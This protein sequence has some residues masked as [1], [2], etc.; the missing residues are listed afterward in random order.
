[1][2]IYRGKGWSIIP[3]SILERDT[4]TCQ[5]CGKLGNRQTLTAHHR[6]PFRLFKDTIKANHPRNLITLCKTCH[7]NAD[8]EYWLRHPHLFDMCRFPYPTCPPRLCQKCGVL[9]ENPKPHTKICEKCATHTC[10]V[11][12]KVF[13]SRHTLA[14][15]VR[16]CLK[17][18][19][20]VFRI[21]LRTY[22]HKCIECNTPIRS[23]RYR[24][25]SCYLKSP[26]L[27]V[28][29]GR[30]PGRKPKGLLATATSG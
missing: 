19:N 27:E 13:I 24:C 4:F 29:P 5:S 21:S 22:P 25:H 10:D 30:K 6:I 17:A 23:G 3:L 28:R 26:S 14:R 2:A 12:G 16:F 11:C 9:I 1:M 20:V 8:N 7:S 18:C 15:Q